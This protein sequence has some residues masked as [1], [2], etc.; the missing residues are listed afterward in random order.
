MFQATRLQVQSSSVTYSI[1]SQ[2]FN[3]LMQILFGSLQSLASAPL[4]RFSMS[5]PDVFF[6][7][8][9]VPTVL[10]PALS[11]STE[12]YVQ[13]ASSYVDVMR[14]VNLTMA[15]APIA[16]FLIVLAIITSKISTVE[17]HKNG[18]SHCLY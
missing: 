9:N 16:V 13:N 17:C 14:M 4:S 8:T 11:A 18:T 6:V 12:D 10:L 2:H 5:D 15:L 7:L 3:D 1:V